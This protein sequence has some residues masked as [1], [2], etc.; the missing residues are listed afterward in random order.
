MV[1]D[2]IAPLK[3]GPLIDLSAIGGKR[4][5]YQECTKAVENLVSCPFSFVYLP[6]IGC[7]FPRGKRR[8]SLNNSGA[9]L[10]ARGSWSLVSLV[11]QST[12][13]GLSCLF[14]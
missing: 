12:V 3:E 2:D 5:H 9:D 6:L 13:L 8:A 1:H 11:R 10:K 14:G 7:I 4:R